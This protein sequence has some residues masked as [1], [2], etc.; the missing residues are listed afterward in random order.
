LFELIAGFSEVVKDFGVVLAL[1]GSFR[2]QLEGTRIEIAAI[3][4]DP[5]HLS[6]LGIGWV[7]LASLLREII[8]LTSIAR[9]LGVE[10]RQLPGGGRVSRIGNEDLLVCVGW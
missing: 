9:V 3:A 8:S 7:C 4:Q 10:E 5:E 1:D 6:D 2:Q